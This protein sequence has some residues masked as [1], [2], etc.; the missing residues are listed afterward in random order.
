MER[1]LTWSPT[2]INYIGQ[3]YEN[4]SA[5]LKAS[6]KAAAIFYEKAIHADSKYLE[7]L[8]SLNSISTHPDVTIDDE[9]ILIALQSYRMENHP[10]PETDPRDPSAK[11]LQTQKNYD[12]SP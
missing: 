1:C 6:R 5:N 4:G 2:N 12:F 10:D 3:Y 9:F 8:S 7:A 11:S